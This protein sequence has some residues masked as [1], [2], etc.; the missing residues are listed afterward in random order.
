MFVFTCFSI[1]C[2]YKQMISILTQDFEA[3]W[4]HVQHKFCSVADVI[5]CC[6]VHLS[7]ILIYNKISGTTF[8]SFTASFPNVVHSLLLPSVVPYQTMFPK[9]IPATADMC[10]IP[11]DVPPSTFIAP[12]N[13]DSSLW[14]FQNMG[15]PLFL[16]A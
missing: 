12:L 16:H 7:V 2:K 11:Y 13:S 6:I 4:E 3:R 10:H 8:R 15:P 9:K 5:I 14:H 1:A